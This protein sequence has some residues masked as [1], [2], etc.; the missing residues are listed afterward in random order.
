MLE[1]LQIVIVASRLERAN[2]TIVVILTLS[3]SLEEV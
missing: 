1:K 3:W 2:N